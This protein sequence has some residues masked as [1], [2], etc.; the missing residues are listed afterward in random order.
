MDAEKLFMIAIIGM[1]LIVGGG[2]A[3]LIFGDDGPDDTDPALVN[4]GQPVNGSVSF[5]KYNDTYLVRAIPNVGYKFDKWVDQNG[6]TLSTATEYLLVPNSDVV[7]TPLFVRNPDYALVTLTDNGHGKTEWDGAK[8]G[9]GFFKIGST[10]K[11][12]PKAEDGY[13][14]R[15]LKDSE[16]TYG[17]E[18]TVTGDVS[19]TAVYGQKYTLTI[20]S[21]IANQ[22]TETSTSTIW[23]GDTVT[24]DGQAKEGYDFRG[25]LI[26]DEYVGTVTFTVGNEDVELHNM[27]VVTGSERTVTVHNEDTGVDTVLDRTFYPGD[28][29]TVHADP[30]L[31]GNDRTALWNGTVVGSEYTA[32]VG[33]DD[34]V[35]TCSYH[36]KYVE[37]I[38]YT[39]KL[40]STTK[41][42]NIPLMEFGST[43]DL[44]TI[45]QLNDGEKVIDY[46]DSD[47]TT[48][49]DGLNTYRILSDEPVVYLS[50]AVE[51]YDDVT[52]DIDTSSAEQ[53]TV[54]VTIESM[55][56]IR[57]LTV[58][59]TEGEDTTVIHEMSLNHI[60]LTFDRSIDTVIQ[61][62]VDY[63]ESPLDNVLTRELHIR[64]L[65]W[66]YQTVD[67]ALG[68]LLGDNN[69]TGSVF[70]DIPSDLLE[71][72]ID[73]DLKRQEA[74]TSYADYTATNAVI[75]DLKSKLDHIMEGYD[76]VDRLNCLIK[77]VQSIPYKY[78]DNSKEKSKAYGVT[79]FD[80]WDM[81]VE[82]LWDEKGDCEDHAFLFAALAREMGFDV[83]L[84]FVITPSGPDAEKRGGH[85]AALIRSEQLDEY[86]E[87]AVATY[88]TNNKLYYYTVGN[89]SERYYFY[90]DD[91]ERFYYAESTPSIS[92]NAGQR[93]KNGQNVGYMPNGYELY[94]SRYTAIHSGIT[95]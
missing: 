21:N 79:G 57:M 46:L 40:G 93:I 12:T 68:S 64:H 62:N 72:A 66:R 95:A 35:I 88:D 56:G 32:T 30:Q 1:V 47:K 16:T 87:N 78:D 34:M 71:A 5:Q 58:T 10:I 69:N 36:D 80:Y 18:F 94:L 90:D 29:V 15:E 65:T 26:G 84:S 11:F 49:L 52:I 6:N 28:T 13:D 48:R 22:S 86:F 51:I 42:Q 7:I 73:A 60:V 70:I 2:A 38:A 81:P 23:T 54:T 31:I 63:K 74:W 76:E 19:L 89:L 53:V 50:V 17:T 61:V 67:G 91:G 9:F 20:H 8:E 24:L 55:N 44:N 4:V 77:M 83:A 39:I 27:Y 3:L 92:D 43:V 75:Q 25:W 37:L 33:D 85:M 45:V 59:Y 14:L 41:I 82:L